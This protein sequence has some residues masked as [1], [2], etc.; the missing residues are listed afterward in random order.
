M[1][2]IRVRRL[3]ENWDPVYGNGQRDYLFDGDAIAQIIETRLRLWL[4]EW[5]EDRS[6]GLPMFQR[7]LGV[8]GS[9]KA[10]VDSLIQRRISETI[11]VTGIQ[12]FVSEFDSETRSYRCEASVYTIFGAILVTGGGA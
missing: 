3:D 11:H 9:T 10:I 2:T 8:R 7:I 6:E 1:S 4:A 5:W 12:S